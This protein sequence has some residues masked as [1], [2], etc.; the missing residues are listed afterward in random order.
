M[1]RKVYFG[2]STKQTWIP[3][4]QSGLS[5]GTS[6]FISQAQL[7]SGRQ[8]VRRSKASSRSFGTSWVGPMNAANIEDSIYTVKDFADGLYG[9]GPFYW[10]DPYA[11]D[12]NLLP[13]HWAAPMLSGDDWPAITSIATVT[14]TTTPA[15]N[16]NYPYQ[17]LSL[18]FGATIIE[19]TE[20]FRV[21][22]PEGHKMHFGWHG[23]Q[24]SG[25]ATVIVRAYDR[26]TGAATDIETSPIAV[27]SQ[28]RTN[29]Q[30]RGNDYS[31]ADIFFKNTAAS[32]SVIQVSGMIMQVLP[33][34][35]SVDQ[36]GFISGRGTTALQFV[37]MPEMEYY[38]AKVNGGQIGLTA[39]FMEV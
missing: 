17:S 14:K 20:K 2:N 5:A 7:L 8:S 31:H 9:E 30:V 32:T 15:N 28:T 35:D 33:D 4:P 38:S 11:I 24:S 19:P 37:Q 29:T 3:A 6:S 18:S 34:T 26:D 16:Y 12:T 1:N 22:I 36:G 39:T 13:P 10:L 25:E 21:I 27:T 23:V